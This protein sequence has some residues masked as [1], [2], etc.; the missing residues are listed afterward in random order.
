MS[1]VINEEVFSTDYLP[2]KIMFR[3]SE[4][5]ELVDSIKY[6][7]NVFVYGPTG[8]GKTL[9]AKYIISQVGGFYV[10]CWTNNTKYLIAKELVKQKSLKFVEGKSAEHLFL[11]LSKV[12]KKGVFVFDE[13]DKAANLSFLYQVSE[14][15]KNS[16]IILISNS[17]DTLRRIEPRVSSRLVLKHLLFAPYNKEQLFEILKQRAKIGLKPNSIS[18]TLLKVIAQY[19]LKRD[20]RV[21]IKILYLASKRAKGKVTIDDI[22]F[23]M[24]E[25]KEVYDLDE[26]DSTIVSIIKKKGE[27][28]S[29]DLYSIYRKEGGK[30]SYRSFKRH[31]DQLSKR[32]IIRMKPTGAGFKGRSNLISLPEQ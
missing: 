2:E 5:K 22:R 27:I 6:N 14:L 1:V 20:L 24:G 28:K 9:V 3:N 23:A 29:G 31:L 18:D 15:F 26:E 30:L 7:S 32:G 8:V 16:T 11:L 10:N 25:S 19:S 17:L 4:I 12:V 13:I 21:G